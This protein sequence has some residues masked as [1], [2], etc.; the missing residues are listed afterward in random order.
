MFKDDIS[1]MIQFGWVGFASSK[2]SSLISY[3]YKQTGTDNNVQAGDFHNYVYSKFQ[4][5]PN[6]LN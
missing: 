3:T 6:K 1:C 2:L 5:Q 4:N